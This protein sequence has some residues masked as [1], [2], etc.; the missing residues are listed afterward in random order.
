[1]FPV[2]VLC[3]LRGTFE[4]VLLLRV[5][6]VEKSLPGCA[7]AGSRFCELKSA[8]SPCGIWQSSQFSLDVTPFDVMSPTCDVLIADGIVLGLVKEMTLSE[9]ETWVNWRQPQ[10]RNLAT[11]RQPKRRHWVGAT[12]GVGRWWW[13]CCRRI[14]ISTARVWSFPDVSSCDFQISLL[15]KVLLPCWA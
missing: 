15:S 13:S 7:K 4:E 3:W 2:H 10:S 1:M 14:L 5:R 6:S 8:L 11:F 12:V 9:R